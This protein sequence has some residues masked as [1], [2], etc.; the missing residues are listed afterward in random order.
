MI[1]CKDIADSILE[2]TKKTASK[3]DLAVRPCIAIILVGNN[4]AAKTYVNNK[5]K[6]CTEMNFSYKIF[7]L[8]IASSTAELLLLIAQLNQDNNVHAILVQMPLPAHINAKLVINSIVQ[9]KDV[10]GFSYKNLGLLLQGKFDEAILPCT[11]KGI[12]YLIDCVLEKD[13]NNFSKNKYAGLLCVILGRSDIVGK[14]LNAILINLGAT[15]INCNRNTKNINNLLRIADIVIVAIGDAQAIN[16]SY[17]QDKAL[18]IDVG[19]NFIN[20]KI[21]GDINYSQEI[22][23]N[24]Q[25]KVTPVPKGVG[26]ITVAMLMN[27]I[28]NCYNLINHEQ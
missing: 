19:I 15:V 24:K 27:N 16:L 2:T 26:L 17:M 1:N 22:I 14:P 20:E 21:Y 7:N 18:I 6:R 23:N 4:L 8:D 12:M 10:D 3:I 9:Q 13:N 28:L 11:P 5:I 25:L